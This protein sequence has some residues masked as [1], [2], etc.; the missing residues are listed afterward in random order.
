MKFVK[1]GKEMKKEKQNS[2]VR[3]RRGICNGGRNADF[4]GRENFNGS[5]VIKYKITTI[6]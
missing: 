5:F 1:E 4:K 3:E 6:L 2:C